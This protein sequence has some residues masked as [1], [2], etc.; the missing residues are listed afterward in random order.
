MTVEN[1]EK[2]TQEELQDNFP[3]VKKDVQFKYSGKCKYCNVEIQFSNMVEVKIRRDS[4]RRLL[5][6]HNGCYDRYF[7]RTLD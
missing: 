1:N 6:Y 5:L 2:I 3:Q 4:T 7:R